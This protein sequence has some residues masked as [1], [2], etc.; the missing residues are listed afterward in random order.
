MKNARRFCFAIVSTLILSLA[1]TIAQKESPPPT[2][3][4]DPTAQSP[5]LGTFTGRVLLIEGQPEMTDLVVKIDRFA[6]P[7]EIQ[8]YEKV[9]HNNKFGQD[10]L[11]ELLRKHP[12]MG[13]FSTRAGVAWAF[14]LVTWEPKGKGFRI[15]MAANRVAFSTPDAERNPR[16]YHFLVVT[17]DVDANG[18]GDGDFYAGAKLGFNKKHGLQVSDNTLNPA[19]I[20]NIR[21]QPK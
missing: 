8:A 14:K 21:L 5:P 10:E 19:A 4:Q 11:T 3:L 15:L 17:L 18:T 7:E 16:D 6:P 20:F 9:L 13:R 1:N 2:P 12:E